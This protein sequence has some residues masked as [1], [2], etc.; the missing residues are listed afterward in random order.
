[1]F[2][3]V[4]IASAV[5]TPIGKFGGQLSSL[6]AT[7]LGAIVIK[8]ALQRANIPANN[9]SEVL[10]GCVIQA[11]LGQNIARQS[12][13]HAGIPIE[14]PATTINNVC[15]SS[16]KAVNLAASLIISGQADIVVAGGTESMSQAPYLLKKARFGYRMG[17]DQ[18][19]DSMIIDSLWD[20]FNNCH[21]GVTA[22]NIAEE[23][24]ISRIEQD[25]FA[26]SSQRKCERA[27]IN[28]L[29]KKEIV[30]ILVKQKKENLI[31][32]KDEFPRDGVTLE[33]ISKL[34]PA[35]KENGT[36]TAANSSG[37]NDGAACVILISEKKIK[38]LGI[39]PIAKWICGAHVGVDPRI[40]GIGAGVAAKKIMQENNFSINDIDLIEANEAFASQ[41]IASSRIAGWNSC[42]EKVNVNGGAIAL[43]HPVGAS[44]CRILVTLIHELNRRNLKYGLATLCVGGGMGVSTIVE[45]IN[46]NEQ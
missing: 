30:P 3:K 43:G 24:G 42:M 26:V 32:D 46:N 25:E 28:G 35:F 29:F 4:Y 31:V 23:Y 40:M 19:C 1:M 21:M 39:K 18:I 13:I 15:G 12:A 45:G 34:K 7:E 36:V 44:G 16:L 38:E 27:R 10:F 9:V 33:S 5:R 14:V 8:E 17:N 2:N 41:S 37:I 6:S 11:G 22:E 20:F